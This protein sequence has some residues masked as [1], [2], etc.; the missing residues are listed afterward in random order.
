VT[1]TNGNGKTVAVAL[2]WNVALQP[3]EVSVP[4]M[5]RHAAEGQFK[6]GSMEPTIDAAMRFVRSAGA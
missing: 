5:E 3:G 6:A 1:Q 2:G 4:E